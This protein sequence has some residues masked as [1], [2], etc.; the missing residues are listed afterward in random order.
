MVNA[1]LTRGNKTRHALVC[2]TDLI[3]HVVAESTRIYAGSAHANDFILFHDG[4]RYAVGS[5]HMGL[6]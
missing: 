4:R 5:T 6:L 2:V 3:D 1:V